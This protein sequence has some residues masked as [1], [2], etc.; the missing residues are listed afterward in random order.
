MEVLVIWAAMSLIFLLALMVK[1]FRQIWDRFREAWL[2]GRAG[3]AATGRELVPEK[4]FVDM[5]EPPSD[6]MKALSAGECII[7]AGEELSKPCGIPLWRSFVLGLVEWA[8]DRRYID[9]HET[10]QSREAHKRGE[11]D[12]VADAVIER[13]AQQPGLIYEYA[14][15]MYLKPA[16][17]SNVHET[18]AQIPF[19]GAITP[20]LDILLERS[21]A[22]RQDDLF[23]PDE[24]AGI[25]ARVSEK[26]R[27]MLKIRGHWEQPASINL[28]PGRAFAA[29][30]GSPEYRQMAT[31]LL[32]ARTLL[33]V[34]MSLEDVRLLVEPAVLEKEPDRRHFAIVPKTE[35]PRRGV[36]GVLRGRGVLALVYPDG[37]TQRICDFLEKLSAAQES[38]TTA[39]A[40]E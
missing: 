8:A 12:R 16:A 7:V 25:S 2:W 9:E 13:F 40:G 20:N 37:D 26:R 21:L 19:A 5:L 4:G 23:N 6:L 15:G 24:I 10:E 22:M 31:F 32:T 33:F 35:I 11:L 17:I 14:R 29:C 3:R 28:V 30:A 36:D 1:V 18:L 39:V 38:A 27:F 34:G